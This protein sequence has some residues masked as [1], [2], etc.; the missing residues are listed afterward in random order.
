[1]NSRSSSGRSLIFLPL[2]L[3]MNKHAYHSEAAFSINKRT[4]FH[5]NCNDGQRKERQSRDSEQP[6]TSVMFDTDEVRTISLHLAFVSL[7]DSWKAANKR[8]SCTS[9]NL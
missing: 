7:K 2:I 4:P 1:M 6:I 5:R 3:Q 9:D 8:C